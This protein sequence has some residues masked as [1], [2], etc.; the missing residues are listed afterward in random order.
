MF[1]GL[2][3]GNIMGTPTGHSSGQGL[4]NAYNP[5]A[6]QAGLMQNQ[7]AQQ[8]AWN[9][10]H[11]RNI[12]ETAKWM[13]DGKSMT[14]QEFVAAVFPEDTPERTFFLLKYSK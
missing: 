3:L 10:I 4:A 14:F 12:P 6:Q 13:I 8:H 2:G 7:A 1:S 11:A 5:Y 9:S